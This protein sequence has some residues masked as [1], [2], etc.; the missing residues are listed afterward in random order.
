MRWEICFEKKT[1]NLTF[2]PPFPNSQFKE[3][4]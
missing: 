1:K 2:L 3:D 4:P